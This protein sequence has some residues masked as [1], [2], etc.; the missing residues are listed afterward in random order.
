[1]K[2]ALIFTIVAI[3]AIIMLSF[4]AF[5]QT[6]SVD[7]MSEDDIV[8]AITNATEGDEIII[9]VKNDMDV[10]ESISLSNSINVTV[11]FN[12][13]QLNYIGS[14]TNDVT[15][16]CF[17]V[18]NANA[19]LTL[20]GSNPMKDS[21][22]YSHYDDTVKPDLTGTGN[23]IVVTYGEIAINNA[24]LHSSN[25]AWAIREEIA[26][27][28]DVSIEITNSVI[29]NPQGSAFSPISSEGYELYNY[30]LIERKIVVADSVIYGG[31]KGP[32]KVDNKG[33][34]YFNFTKN[35]SFTNV[36]FYDFAI[37]NDSWYAPDKFGDILCNS[38]ENSM[39]MR[40]CEFL[41]YDGTKGNVNVITYTGKHN[42]NLINC[43]YLEITGKLGSDKGGKAYVFVTIEPTCN[44]NG[45]KTTYSG[46][47]ITSSTPEN[48]SALGHSWISSEKISYPD[49]YLK[50]GYYEY[51]CER[52]SETQLSDKETEALFV[53]LGYSTNDLNTAVVLGTSI[54]NKAIE[55]FEAG[56]GIKLDFGVMV[57]NENFQITVGEN[58]YEI[59]N[60]SKMSIPQRGKYESFDLIVK[61]I[62]EG[63]HDKKIVMEFYCYDGSK[64]SYADNELQKQSYNEIK[65][66]YNSVATKAK[67]LL[68]SKIKLTYNDDGSFRV[69]I[70]SDLHMNTSA[71][72]TDV[73]E[74]KDR[75]KLLVDRENP[76]FI[77]FTGDN[78]I[79]SS[80]EAKLRAN[81][82]A[83]VS[84]IEEKQIPWCHVYGNHDQDNAL[85]KAAQQKI[86]ES[87][88]YCISKDVEELSGVG[89]YVHAVYNQDGTIGSVIY[90]LDSGATAQ[91]GGF[92]YIK[93]DQIAWYKETSELLQKY[94]GGKIIP[95]IMAFHIPLTE[96]KD[97]YNNRNNSSIV[98]EA[99]G[100]RNEEICCSNTD[101]NLFETVLERRDVKAIVTGHDHKNDYM[102]NYKGVKLCSSP[103]ISDLT[104]YDATIQGSRVFDLNVSTINNVKTYV[105]YIIERKYFDTDASLDIGSATI[106][107]TG[108]DNSG[109]NGSVTVSVN[110]NGLIEVTRSQTGNFELDIVFNEE[111]YARLGNN[112][113]LIVYVDFT[114]VDFRKACFGLLSND[115]TKPYRTDDYDKP[116]PLYYLAD[117][118]S[119]W[120]TINHG[121]DG[122][123]GTAQNSSVIGLKGY[124]A[125]PIANFQKGTT[126]MSSETL[127][128]GIY[129]YADISSNDYAN[130][131]FYYGNFAL[132][133][134]YLTYFE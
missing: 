93:E 14:T 121:N 91:D 13:N 20:N 123:F 113:Y 76:D 94:N 46:M 2:K 119:E 124:F 64:I 1:M 59:S 21:S 82:D 66:N 100:N 106:N 36:R 67:E 77:I 68:E 112:K 118:S 8:N 81:I 131:P 133:D 117:G 109:L 37:V 50:A 29:R 19:S 58:G 39:V 5:A 62:P 48:L 95:A 30:Y 41:N 28:N 40:N 63:G 65:A 47:T 71:N 111:N 57:G 42:I 103:N 120:Q 35:S 4:T 83:M 115:G 92:D 34:G 15:K 105:S 12:G 17:Y 96:N 31:F 78:T 132:T 24:Y 101:T 130:K 102:F 11:N 44:E 26:E 55:A 69:L 32:E 88:E 7:A 23:L 73:Q 72:A 99:E 6:V 56:S 61:N 86:Y 33:V 90:L 98:I 3:L 85:T 87:Y 45:E 16:A 116:S 104:Y 9:N 38:Y 74:V 110:A 43:K 10:T 53:N 129:I 108:Y 114:N 54:N 89:N 125:L 107:K 60:G 25:V 122:C 49:G 27:D 18:A 128:T 127:V 22:K 70:L 134:D 126:T 51:A 79:N 97:A 84:Y 75:V 80:S 52:C